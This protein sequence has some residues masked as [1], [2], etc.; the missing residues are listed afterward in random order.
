M[1]Y[2]YEDVRAIH[3]E[4][5]E[6]CQAACPMCDRNI[7]GGKD[8]PNLGMHELYL[9]DIK[10]MMPPEFVQQLERIYMCGNFGDPIVA[11]DTLEVMQYF[12]SQK[13]E[14][15]LG[16][17]TNAGAKKPDWWR[18]LAKTL[19]NWSYVKFGFDGLKDT[20]HLYRQNVNWDIAWENALA[21]IDA[22]GKAHWDYLIFEH[23]E[24]QVEEARALSEKVGFKKFIPKKTGR[25]FST[26]KQT[27][28][29]EHQA[30][31]RKGSET[32]LLQQPK[33][34]KYQ[35]KALDKI[36]EITDKHGSLEKYFDNVQISCKVAAE[37]NMYI[38]AEGLVLPCCWVAG[39]MYKWWQKPGENQVWELLQQSG[40]KD[41]F[42][43][44]KHGI[45]YVLNNEYFSHRLVDSWNKPNVHAGKP[46]VCSQKCG[47][48]FDAFAEQFK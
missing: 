20:N 45:K 48:E 42:N 11:K 26:M 35:N 21:F 2:K 10:E 17:N 4:I 5:T 6:K 32:Q 8:N 37:K 30:I 27:K 41:E 44:K 9:D 40:G 43:A 1:I 14:L 19:G 25:F 29:D 31:N 3:L 34:V 18:E 22:G 39:N 15:T 23:N 12:R 46:M 38:S 13:R 16:M 24:H 47:K 7:H 28:K 36:K 33:E